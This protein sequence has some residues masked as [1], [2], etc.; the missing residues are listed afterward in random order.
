MREENSPAPRRTRSDA[1]HHRDRSSDCDPGPGERSLPGSV[2]SGPLL[3][4]YC[5]STIS[6]H[7]SAGL[8]CDDKESQGSKD[9]SPTRRSVGAPVGATASVEVTFSKTDAAEVGGEI[10]GLER[11]CRSRCRAI[12]AKAGNAMVSPYEPSSALRQAMEELNATP[13]GGSAIS[14]H[15]GLR[16]R[17]RGRSGGYYSSFEVFSTCNKDAKRAW[18]TLL[19]AAETG[20]N[21]KVEGFGAGPAREGARPMRHAGARTLR[22]KRW[23]PYPERVSHANR[24]GQSRRRGRLGEYAKMNPHY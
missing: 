8:L 13:A 7:L 3:L 22:G 23:P 21:F 11:R 4:I 2:R 6:V 10:R 24:R 9:S 1:A 14:G 16:V 19:S 15:L 18:T 5:E 17:E 12:N 20:A